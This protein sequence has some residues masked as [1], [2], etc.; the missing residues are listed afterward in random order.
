MITIRQARPRIERTILPNEHEEDLDAMVR[1]HLQ[2]ERCLH[3]KPLISFRQ[4][5]KKKLWPSWYKPSREP[6][7]GLSERLVASVAESFGCEP[8]EIIGQHRNTVLVQARGIVSCVLSA[9]GWSYPMIGRIMG[10]RDHSTIINQVKQIRNR[11]ERG[12]IFLSTVLER[13]MKRFS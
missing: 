1:E 9:R 3:P 12:D 8:Y 5:N 6:S 4:P 7:I 2:Q 11:I 13:H 10:G